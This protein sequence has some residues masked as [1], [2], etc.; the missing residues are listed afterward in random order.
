MRMPAFPRSDRAHPRDG[1]EAEEP[2]GPFDPPRSRNQ[3]V[4]W[5]M[6]LEIGRCLDQ[7]AAILAPRLVPGIQSALH[8]YYLGYVTILDLAGH[9]A[10]GVPRGYFGGLMPQP[11][12]EALHQAARDYLVDTATVAAAGRI[13]E[14]ALL[15]K[16]LPADE[17]LA[18]FVETLKVL[19]AAIRKKSYCRPQAQI[20]ETTLAF[21][22]KTSRFVYRER[23]SDRRWIQL[24]VGV[25]DPLES[26]NATITSRCRCRTFAPIEYGAQRAFVPACVHTLAALDRVLGLLLEPTTPAEQQIVDELCQP[27]WARLLKGVE[28][29]RRGSAPSM[30][31]AQRLAWLLKKESTGGT[32]RPVPVLQN[33][34]KRGTFS[35]GRQA[36]LRV[37]HDRADLLTHPGD[38][39]AL[40]LLIA[41]GEMRTD[42]YYQQPDQTQTYNLVIT[43]LLGRP[44]VYLAQN[45]GEPAEVRRGELS[46]RVQQAKGGALTAEVLLDGEATSLA[47]VS[48][49]IEANHGPNLVIGR[50]EKR[51]CVV[52]ELSEEQLALVELL[53][54]YGNN[55]PG[56]AQEAFL[57]RLSDLE[58]IVPV[59]LPAE[60]KGRQVPAAETLVVRLLPTG[61]VG[62]EV[63]ILCRPVPGGRSFAPGQGS[64]EAAG[65]AGTERV[66]AV[67]D[68]AAEQIRARLVVS[69]LEI[70][71]EAEKEPFAF[72]VDQGE[73]AL[74]LVARLGE[75]AE[76]NALIV[77]WPE[78][79]WSVSRPATVQDLS[80][81]VSEGE[82]WFGLSGAIEVGGDRLELAVLFEAVRER[83]RYVQVRGGRYLAL[84]DSLRRRL[85]MVV[86][87][88]H[89]G[90]HGM[91]LTLAAS[92]VLED[93]AGDAKQ[94]SAP[95]TWLELAIRIRQA[96]DLDPEV[97]KNLDGV[98]RHYQ[99][100]GFKWLMRLSAWG[101]GG[102]LAD[103]MGLGK[104]VEAIAMLVAR[105]PNGPALVIAPTSVNSNWAHEIRRFAPTLR[106]IL[107]REAASSGRAELVANLAA[108]DVLICSFGL[109]VADGEPVCGREYATLIVDEAQAVKNAAT[110]RAKACR[111]IKAAFRVALTGTPIENH[112]GEL[113]SIYRIVFPGL[114]G[115]F[116]S[117]RARFGTCATDPER[118]Q[119]LAK[120]VRP[121]LLRRT[122]K[123]VAPELPPRVVSDVPV[124]LSAAE[125]HLYEDARL[126][127]VASLL[128]PDD[129]QTD[130]RFQILA[131]L[132]RLRLIA[133]HP[134]LGD[135]K[136]TIPSAKLTRLLEIVEEL[137]EE[138]HRALVFSQFTRHL[139]LV[140][141][142]LDARG[143][144]YLYLDGQTPAANRDRLVRDFQT[145]N[146]PLFLISLR[147]GGTG[148]NLTA[149]DYVL[150]LD[151]WWNPAVEDQATDRAHRIG[152]DKPVTVLRLVSL[153]TIEEK[154]L[155]LH[156]KKRALV[157]S[158]LD[159]ASAA[160][161]LSS[162]EML[163]L[164]AE[165]N[166]VVDDEPES[167]GRQQARVRKRKDI[168]GQSEEPAP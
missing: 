121:F 76:Q 81:A 100:E 3:L 133:C 65:F 91:D 134:R 23:G 117:F 44:H 109:T 86:D 25:P 84:A 54:K 159:G 26:G 72:A 13:E 144:A 87:L 49:L 138:D 73:Q 36:S 63:S 145:G 82:D 141:E 6:N 119:V 88:V 29:L 40:E 107:Y 11:F 157:E 16:P 156:G 69:L 113:W 80:L 123:E 152:Q 85:E 10:K 5:A 111:S 14:R 158:I 118:R 12:I 139:A 128:A 124:A 8:N 41:L 150:H 51:L 20:P 151:P 135:D 104:T 136:A 15:K 70:R 27:G 38:R 28:R 115:S 154:I 116:D 142:A 164:L 19:R 106:P 148:L 114:F 108:G 60:L 64:K 92:A 30:P 59:A 143:I 71:A 66:Y 37:L 162:D 79:A 77:E 129:N 89:A 56:T 167:G 58:S 112:L 126:A 166:P 61:E 47:E 90:R 96:R 137:R 125:R 57:E 1:R 21:E 99:V 168:S 46:L 52:V 153:G 93:L 75:V 17:K 146:V 62:L 155:A 53:G 9:E 48:D 31:G 163:S 110:Q 120:V 140:R 34:N 50:P 103:D 161:K 67:R 95:Q 42:R 74:D 35:W 122:K 98:L 132:T 102:V 39:Q 2:A 83:R 131:A 18:R 78:K 45:A 165:T 24:F 43:H 127:A 33:Q 32:L 7:P 97:P 149:A 55:L 94:F 105:A 22:S 68:L 147:A 130:H 4:S 160:A 101:A